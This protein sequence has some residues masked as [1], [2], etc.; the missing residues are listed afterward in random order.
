[1]TKSLIKANIEGGKLC[2][3]KIQQEVIYLRAELNVEHK[4]N[5]NNI[6]CYDVCTSP[7]KNKDVSTINYSLYYELDENVDTISDSSK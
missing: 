1:M 6:S 2:K 4:P 3:E 7:M 5:I